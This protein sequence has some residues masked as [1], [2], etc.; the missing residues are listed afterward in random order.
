MNT[1]P[2]IVLLICFG[3][4]LAVLLWVAAVQRLRVTDEPGAAPAPNIEEPRSQRWEPQQVSPTMRQRPAKQLGVGG[5]AV[6]VWL[7]LWLF[8]LSVAAPV[9]LIIDHYAN[10]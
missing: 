8:V 2:Y 6:G 7:G 3:L 4:A 1:V 9:L 10:K 5:V